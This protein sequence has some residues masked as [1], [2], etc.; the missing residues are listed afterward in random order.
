[1]EF[2]EST[3]ED[4][5][6]ADNHSISH[7]TKDVPEQID[8]LYTLEH[9]GVPLCVGGF[10]MINHTTAWCHVDLT[11]KAGSHIIE[12]YRVIKEWIESFCKEHGIIRLQAY[13]REDFPE[14][15]RMVKHLG[16]DYE[17]TMEKFMGDK[18]ALMYKRII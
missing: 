2:R 7:E 9:E 13:V 16:F 15:M 4:V 6:Y 8:Y 3:T 12:V 18:D 11:D 17:F 1:M 5:E 14:G 10:R